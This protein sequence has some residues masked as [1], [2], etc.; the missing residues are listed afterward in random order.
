M[1]LAAQPHIAGDEALDGRQDQIVHHR[2]GVAHVRCAHADGEGGVDPLKIFRKFP[3]KF[4]S[5]GVGAVDED[6][7]PSTA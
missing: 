5:A 3:R 7:V 4:P 6:D 1:E 2:A